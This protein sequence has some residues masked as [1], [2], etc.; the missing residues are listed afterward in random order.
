M[1]ATILHGHENQWFLPEIRQSVGRNQIDQ[2][3][4]EEQVHGQRSP[5]EPG[6]DLPEAI[7]MVGGLSHQ[8]LP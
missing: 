3:D 1:G 6:E 7:G 4:G 2:A 5:T 8:S